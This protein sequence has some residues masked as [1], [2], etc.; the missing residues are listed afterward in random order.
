MYKYALNLLK[1]LQCQNPTS[2]LS[3]SNLL[4]HHPFLK[5]SS[6]YSVD[7]I[8]DNKI[9]KRYGILKQNESIVQLNDKRTHATAEQWA[10]LVDWLFEIVT[11]FEKSTQSVFMAMNYVDL[12]ISKTKVRNEGHCG[13]YFFQFLGSILF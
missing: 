12:F 4:C 10:N 9:C 8:L 7:E 13:A 11:V 1:Q 6:N 5:K 3:I 2:L